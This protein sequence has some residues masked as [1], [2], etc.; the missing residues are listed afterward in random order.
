MKTR[1]GRNLTVM[2]CF[3]KL[4]S[5]CLPL[6]YLDRKNICFGS[7]SLRARGSF[8]GLEL[9]LQNDTEI[10]DYPLQKPP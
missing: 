8:C 2:L 6:D 10:P 5:A 4:L 1:R 9:F 7:S 3:F